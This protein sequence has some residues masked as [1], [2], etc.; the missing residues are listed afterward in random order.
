MLHMK[1]KDFYSGEE[2]DVD[3]KHD[4]KENWFQYFVLIIWITFIIL[5]ILVIIKGV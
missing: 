5:L 2:I 3:V 4:W 1:V